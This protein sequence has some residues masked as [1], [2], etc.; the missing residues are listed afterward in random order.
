[1]LQDVVD[2]L[3]EAIRPEAGLGCQSRDDRRHG[4]T[5]IEQ[6]QG[7]IRFD[8]ERPDQLGKAPL[9]RATHDLHLRQPQMR[10]HHAEPDGE[11]GLVLRIDER[12]LVVVPVDPDRRPDRRGHGKLRQALDE[13]AMRPADQHGAHA[14]TGRDPESEQPVTYHGF[15]SRGARD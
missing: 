12:D 7:A 1:M 3:H 15:L 8:P 11:I 4:T 9:R 2:A 14:D 13:R 5:E 10:V 6:A